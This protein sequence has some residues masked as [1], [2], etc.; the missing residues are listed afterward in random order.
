[1]KAKFYFVIILN[2]DMCLYYAISDIKLLDIMPE[3]S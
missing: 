3:M 1:M 2:I